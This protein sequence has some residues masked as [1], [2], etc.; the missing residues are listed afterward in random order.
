VSIGSIGRFIMPSSVV[1]GT[2][3]SSDDV[4][5]AAQA[6]YI[7]VRGPVTAQVLRDSGGP[8]VESFG[9]PGALLSRVFPVDR[10][11]TNGRTLL[12]RHF[13]HA[14]VPLVLPEGMDEIGVQMSHPLHIEE[15]V[16]T[17]NGYDAV[18][19][20]AMH[21]MIACHSYGIPC[22]L[23]T[24]EGL[25]GAV[26]GSGIKYGDYSRGAGLSTVH[27]PRA[28]SLDL[29]R[30]RLDDLLSLERISQDKLDEIEQ[31]VRLAVAAHLE[32]D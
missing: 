18:V 19:T 7:S 24:F 25:E 21:V 6:N 4:Q 22:A 10:G 8:D 20:S 31:A 3:I 1:V 23:I 13:K 30:Y 16:R 28:V 26:H 17:L 5:L 2:G 9:D 29:R 32:D 11:E 14:N 27:E 15:F 12:V